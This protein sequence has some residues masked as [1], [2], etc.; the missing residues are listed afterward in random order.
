[1]F[2]IGSMFDRTLKVTWWGRLIRFF[3]SAEKKAMLDNPTI[4]SPEQVVS[5]FQAILDHLRSRFPTA[6]I[7][8][9]EYSAVVG[10]DTKAGTD[11]VFSQDQ[12]Q[13]YLHTADTLKD[14]YAQAARGRDR[15]YVVPLADESRDAH[16]LGSKQ[17]W[18]NHCSLWHFYKRDAYHP[19]LAGMQAAADRLFEFYQTSVSPKN[20]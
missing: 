12:I 5:C 7:L 18:A 6:H 16:A 15:V 13:E 10:P 2:Y 19:N 9:L 1:M 4:V 8:L 17:P 11:V 14:I 20:A 3:L